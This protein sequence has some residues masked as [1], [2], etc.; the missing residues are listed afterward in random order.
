MKKGEE[1]PLS[2]DQPHLQDN[3]ANGVFKVS[4]SKPICSRC[5]KKSVIFYIRGNNREYI[6]Q[7]F[8]CKRCDEPI[9][10][11]PVVASRIFRMG[12]EEFLRTTSE[13]FDIILADPA[14]T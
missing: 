12:I 2:P 4:H 11:I 1:G 3:K 6:P 10:P 8:Y 5:G 14:W 9:K 13:R 7:G